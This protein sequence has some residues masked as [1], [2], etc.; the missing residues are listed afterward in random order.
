MSAIF[1]FLQRRLEAGE[2]S[3]GQ[4]LVRP[5]RTLRH[6][7]DGGASDPEIFFRPE[8]AREIA[9]YDAGGNYRPLKTAP[10][11]RRGWELRLADV[12][13]LRL[14]LDYFYPAALGT[15][16]AFE[17][18]ELR[19]VPLR[20]TLARQTGRYRV[21]RNIRDD[22][23]AGVI[24]QTC[25]TGCLRCRLWTINA[26]TGGLAESRRARNAMPVLCVEACNLLV[27]ACRLEAKSNL[28]ETT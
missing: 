2:W 19:A 26:T 28:P 8:A 22:Q 7:A 4:V 14:A 25:E 15:W 20:E 13:D 5:D 21:T 27:S 18:G 1:D 12:D 3:L 11:L 6:V 17:R 23:A 10:N 9:R 16:L 24:A